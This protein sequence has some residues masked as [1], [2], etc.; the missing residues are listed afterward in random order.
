MCVWGKD[1]FLS[2]THKMGMLLKVLLS[3]SCFEERMKQFM[4]KCLVPYQFTFQGIVAWFP[5]PQR[6][7]ATDNVTKNI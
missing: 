7:I 6:T 1:R 2:I 4:K 3:S 5:S